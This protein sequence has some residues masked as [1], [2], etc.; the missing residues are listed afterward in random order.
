MQKRVTGLYKTSS[1]H[2]FSTMFQNNVQILL[3]QK[4]LKPN[5]KKSN[6]HNISIHLN[7][8]SKQPVVTLGTLK[9]PSLKMKICLHLLSDRQFKNYFIGQAS[10]FSFVKSS[11]FGI[12]STISAQKSEK[13]LC[14]HCLPYLFGILNELVHDTLPANRTTQKTFWEIF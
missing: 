13:Y 11:K 3:F 12:L 10:Q 9:L 6:K 14:C 7:Q 2:T 8:V 4:K 5:L 1:M